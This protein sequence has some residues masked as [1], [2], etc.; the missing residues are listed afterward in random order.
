M[1]ILHTADLH[2]GQILYQY[3]DRVD[4][5]D[6]F[7]GQLEGWCNR[8][9]PD[10]LVVCGDVFDIP[11]PGAATKEHFNRVVAGLHR[12]FPT[13]AIVV[14]AGNHDS[15]ARLQADSVVWNLSGVTLLGQ[16]PPMNPVDDGWQD[17]YIVELPSGFIAAMPFSTGSRREAVQAVLDRVAERNAAGKPVVMCG[18]QAMCGADSTG[19]GDI[20]NQR[21]LEAGEMGRGYDYLALG[22]IH[23]PQTLGQ[24]LDDER[25][26]IS[27]Y[28]AGAM[29]YSG[30]ALHVSCD[31]RYPHSVSLVE[32]ERHGG[33]VRVE[34]LRID[35]LR[36][37]Y[38]LPEE[39]QQPAASADEAYAVVQTFCATHTSGYIRLRLD[40]A[41]ALPAG[42]I[43]QI[44]QMLEATGNE[45]RFNPKT[46]WVG[47]P[48]KEAEEEKPRFEMAELQ[49]MSDPLEFVSRTIDQYPELDPE[50]LKDDFAE[51][52]R[53]LKAM[54][55]A[56]ATRQA[57][58][59]TK[60][61]EVAK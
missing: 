8:Y 61:E 28:P 58:K 23:R 16:A 51:I 30:S 15:A 57:Q 25:Q 32:M 2:L 14:I 27:T 11:Q 39:D 12:A 19:H 33:E 17:R 21:V 31:E 52:E 47:A 46:I 35:E 38:I 4:E 43:Q 59:R 49:Q 10:A 24:K 18:H 34:R 13:M 1:K 20:G 36:H 37:F 29:R 55:E 42:F 3:Y 60:G 6:H 7:F 48:E 26:E 22:H 5:H 50:R 41:A 44:Y 56:E 54:E 45:V 40:Y 53:E 9:Q